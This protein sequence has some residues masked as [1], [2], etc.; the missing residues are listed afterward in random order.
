VAIFH[1]PLE[2]VAAAIFFIERKRPFEAT[3]VAA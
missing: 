1:G 2:L 3:S